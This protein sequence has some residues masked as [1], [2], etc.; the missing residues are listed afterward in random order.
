MF[1]K[2]GALTLTLDISNGASSSGAVAR[3]SAREDRAARRARGQKRAG[4]TYKNG[5]AHVRLDLGAT[6]A[7]GATSVWDQIRARVD[8]TEP[9]SLELRR[10]TAES[11]RGLN[12]V[13]RD[14]DATVP[15]GASFPTSTSTYARRLTSLSLRSG[16]GVG[17]E[18]ARILASALANAVPSLRFL[19]LSGNDLGRAGAEALAEALLVSSSGSSYPVGVAAAFAAS[20]PVS[21]TGAVRARGVGPLREPRGERRRARAGDG[22]VAA[23]VSETETTRPVP[24]RHRREGRGGSGGRF[25]VAGASVGGARVAIVVRVRLLLLQGARARGTESETQRVRRRGRGG[26]G[27]RAARV[28]GGERETSEGIARHRTRVALGRREVRAPRVAS[29]QAGIQRG[30]GDWRAR[31]RTL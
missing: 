3:R 23:R 26:G 18:G 2:M 15:F 24:E 5:V 19:D 27:E 11:V 31:W 25:A 20:A 4:V 21:A 7:T 29:A 13:G 17:D 1:G 8:A 9:W 12:D 28:R 22:V 6:G 16:R 10:A 14:G 30:D